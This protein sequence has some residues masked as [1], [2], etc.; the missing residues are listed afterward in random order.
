MKVAEFDYNLPQGL[1]AQEPLEERDSSRLLV[2][3]RKDGSLKEKSF[4][5]IVDFFEQGDVLVLNQSKVIPARLYA[6][7]ETGA[8]IEVLLLEKKEEGV[9]EVLLKPSKRLRSSDEITFKDTPFT[10]RILE[11]TPKAKWRLKFDPGDIKDLIFTK[12]SMPTPPYIKK[13]LG[14]PQRYQ[15]V[16]A[17][18]E[19]SVAAPTAG[20]HFTEAL[21]GRLKAKGV[22]IAYVILH[23]G[24]GTFRSI[25]VEIVED[26]RMDEE[27]YE[28]SGETAATINKAKAQGKRIFACGTSAVRTLESQAIACRGRLQAGRQRTELFIYPG[29]D[30]KVVERLITN[31]HVPRSTNLL[32]AS[33]FA[34]KE[35]IHKA[36]YF[37][38]ARN[39]RFYSFGD[40]MLIL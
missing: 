31:F 35:A 29:F 16:F 30:F 7:K 5:D 25:N 23:V 32:L 4:K 38:I 26:H 34:G 40:A 18:N 24:L 27:Y 22:Q 33:A 39:Y 10:A 36:Y 2:L 6:Y 19:G 12:G 37:A 11:R 21:L 13:K 15:T 20:L 17:R 9:W 28:I 14:D 3:D 1:I 8:K